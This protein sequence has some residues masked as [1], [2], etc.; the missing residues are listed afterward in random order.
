MN[1]SEILGDFCIL[2]EPA[3]ALGLAGHGWLAGLARL[4]AP[5][6]P[7]WPWLAWLAG[8]G[9]YFAAGQPPNTS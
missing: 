5:A 4:P 9:M 1:F 6:W 7:G 2:Y 3:H 8:V